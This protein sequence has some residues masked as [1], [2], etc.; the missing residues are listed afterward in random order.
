MPRSFHAINEYFAPL[1]ADPRTVTGTF[2]VDLLSFTATT[3][4]PAAMPLT[5]TTLALTETVATPLFADAADTVPE[6]LLAVTFPVV[7]TVSEIDVG[8]TVIDGVTVTGKL[9]FRVLASR[10]LIA[11]LPA[12]LP[13]TFSVAPDEVTLVSVTVET[14]VLDDSAFISPAVPLILT[15]A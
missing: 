8:D 7:P 3:V 10:I 14:P 5:V 12:P 2:T 9:T 11:V 13:K 1:V 6:K 15:V 4:A